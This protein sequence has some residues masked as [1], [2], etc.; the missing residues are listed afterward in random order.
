MPT[1]FSSAGVPGA[2]NPSMRTKR[3]SARAPTTDASNATTLQIRAVVSRS[4]RFPPPRSILRRS[5][6][7]RSN[8]ISPAGGALRCHRRGPGRLRGVIDREREPGELLRQP[9]E[10]R[11]EDADREP[12]EPGRGR[13]SEVDVHVATLELLL[14]EREQG[15]HAAVDAAALE[16]EAVVVRRDL[17]GDLLPGREERDERRLRRRVETRGLARAAEVDVERAVGVA[18]REQHLHREVAPSPLLHLR[19]VAARERDAEREQHRD[20]ARREAESVGLVGGEVDEAG[21]QDRLERE[22]AGARGLV[23]ADLLRA[24]EVA[25]DQQAADVDAEAR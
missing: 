14:Q 22:R 11:D 21:D 2:A 18:E 7:A 25:V 8:E 12:V 24:L 6:W 1:L 19:S 20:D 23:P 3:T 17:V 4:I 10:V 9:H 15:L 5:V 13:P 16:R